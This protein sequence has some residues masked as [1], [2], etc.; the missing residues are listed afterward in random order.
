MKVI[1]MAL[2]MAAKNSSEMSVNF[3][4]TTWCSNPESSHIQVDNQY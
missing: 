3:Y 4:Q 1:L 2:V